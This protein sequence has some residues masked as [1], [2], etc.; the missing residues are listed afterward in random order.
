M[1]VFGAEIDGQWSGQENTFTV[2]CGARRSATEFIKI[3]SLATGRG[4]FG[5]AFDWFMPYVTGGA[6]LVMLHSARHRPA[7][8]QHW[9]RGSCPRGVGAVLRGRLRRK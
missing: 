2:A 6:A 5:L 8:R 9:F 3:R 7:K 1:F 4:R